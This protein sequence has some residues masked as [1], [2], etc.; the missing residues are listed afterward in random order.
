MR[1][2]LLLALALVPALGLAGCGNKPDD[3]KTGTDSGAAANGKPVADAGSNL[4]QSAD[5]A[6]S[7]SGAASSDPDGDALTFD[8]SFDHVPDGSTLPTREAPFTANHSAAA[9]AT[10]FS[11]DAVGTYIVKLEVTD[12]RGL[13]SDPDYVIVTIEEPENVPVANAGTDVSVAVGTAVTVDGSRSYDPLGRSL[14]Y[15]WSLVDKPS[16]S[17]VG[18]L[19][20]PTASQ[21]SLTP[22]AKG[23]YVA[24]LVVSNGLAISLADAVTITALGDDHAPVANAGTDLA[25]EDCMSIQLDCSSS[26]DPDGDTLTYQW[27]LQ[28]KP[29]ASTATNA[30]FSDR[31]SGRPTFWPDQAGEY[32]LSCAVSDGTTWSTPD[33]VTLTADERMSNSRPVADAG[34]DQTVDAGSATCEES[35]YS[36]DCDECAAATFTLGG[37]A[38]TTD[39]D[40]DPVTIRWTTENGNVTIAD[41]TSLVTSVTVS[42]T[43]PTE[44]G[45]CEETEVEFTLEVTDCTGASTTDRVIVDVNCCGVADTSSR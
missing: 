2:T 8:W 29:A 5:N 40:G 13:T 12:A 27:E 17:N 23:V 19:T 39:P 10:A 1:S 21:A 16:A 38:T 14:T 45:E 25:V 4:T 20:N 43:T 42:D 32:L 24:N 30:S 9:V 36:Y 41:A 34:I 7:L 35:G 22:D 15:S 18:A 44:P 26:A 3:G 37:T 31:T 11:P 6:V 33:L 28:S